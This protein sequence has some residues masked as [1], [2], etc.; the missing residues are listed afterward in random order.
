MLLGL[1]RQ[2]ICFFP[3]LP[4]ISHLW[5]VWGVASVQGAADMLVLIL[6]IPIGLRV[7]RDVRRLEEGGNW[8]GTPQTTS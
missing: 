8:E 1:S 2:G 4:L 7:M 6:A 5:G 3:I